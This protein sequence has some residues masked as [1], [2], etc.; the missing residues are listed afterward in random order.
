MGNI[1]MYRLEGISMAAR[2]F[3]EEQMKKTDG[4]K[5][6]AFESRYPVSRE[7]KGTVRNDI[8]KHHN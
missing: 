6:E 4:Q 5:P 7:K 1:V 8:E 3:L 2:W